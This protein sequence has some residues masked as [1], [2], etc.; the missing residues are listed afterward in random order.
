MLKITAVKNKKEVVLTFPYS[1]TFVTF[2]KREIPHS[3]RHYSP[4]TKAWQVHTR[5]LTRLCRFGRKCFEQI[6][7]QS[8][9]TRYR[10]ALDR[11]LAREDETATVQ[12][13]S[14]EQALYAKLFLLP[15]AP[16]SLLK[17]AYKCLAGEYH[18]DKGGCAEKFMVLQ[19]A[20]NEILEKRENEPVS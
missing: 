13:L 16:D 18:P 5:Y 10:L 14:E 17:S 6:E 11:V 2:L 7:Y 15:S 1:K 3:E 9:P 19:E 20:Y 8:L 4:K 12:V